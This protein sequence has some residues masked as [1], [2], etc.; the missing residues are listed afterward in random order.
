MPK[1]FDVDDLA[2]RLKE[3]VGFDDVRPAAPRDGV[4]GVAADLVATPADSKQVAAVLAVAS[5]CG[6]A[7]VVRGHGTK[8]KWGA[9]PDALSI[10]VD[11]HRMDA[12][13]EHADGDLIARVQP[14]LPLAALQ[15]SLAKADQRLAVDEVVAGT[16]VGGMI[17][18]GLSG[19]L[20]FAYGSVRD[21]ILGVT[22]ARAD[23]E[24]TKAGGKV[25]KNVAGYDLAKLY[26]GSFGTLGIVTE[27]VLRLQPRPA[28]RLWVSARPTSPSPAE[29]AAVV[30]QLITSPA[31]PSAV[32][33]HARGEDTQ[34]VA[35]VEGSASGAPKRAETIAGQVPG[36]VVADESPD[37]WGKL[38]AGAVLLKV[39]V[40]IAAGADCIARMVSAAR[41]HGIAVEVAGSAGVGVFYAGYPDAEPNVLAGL[42]HSARAQANSAGGSAVVLTAPQ[43]VRAMVDPW[44]PV[45]ALE[46]MRKVKEGFDPG[47]ILAPGRFVGGI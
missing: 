34:L 28:R 17:G 31:V 40:P 12:L 47:R 11:L 38:P 3:V 15:A 9:P 18:S 36:S 45:P 24:V 20:R 27:A 14:G 23:G 30:Q 5:S 6:A 32:E 35:L 25:V 8:L 22:V 39:S 43:P 10:V 4:G 42:I 26:T 37:W 46:L 44:G 7:T 33:V 16:T 2:Q 19:P 13:L 21:L 1:S 29:C 41:G